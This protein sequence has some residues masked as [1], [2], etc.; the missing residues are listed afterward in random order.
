MFPP[1]PPDNLTKFKK[2]FVYKNIST[3]KRLSDEDFTFGS[4]IDPRKEFIGFGYIG[5]DSAFRPTVRAP[6]GWK[7]HI[8]VDDRDSEN[9]AQAWDVIK[10]ILIEWW[11][12]ESKVVKPGISFASDAM[13]C[14][15][16]IT[17]YQFFNPERDWQAII[18]EIELRLTRAEIRS[19]QFSPTDK[20]ITN[21]RYTAYRNDLS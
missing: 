10:D 1:Q 5:D 6:G 20:P 9:I 13:Q 16:Q 15:K 3:Q 21:S 11:I 8:A 14:S 19:G 18:Q 17:I 12:V 7:L 2:L 4:Q